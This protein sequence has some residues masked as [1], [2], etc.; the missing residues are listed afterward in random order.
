MEAL[1][2]PAFFWSRSFVL[3]TQKKNR[4]LNT[5]R[6]SLSDC[7]KKIYGYKAQQVQ[8]SYQ[9][10]GYAPL[11]KIFSIFAHA[12]RGSSYLSTITGLFYLPSS[13][14]ISSRIQLPSLWSSPALK[15]R[16]THCGLEQ[17]RI[18]TKVMGHS[19]VRSRIRSHRSLVRL[20]RTARFARALRCAHSLAH[21]A[22]SLAR[23]K[24]NY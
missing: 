11:F 8:K 7:A 23:G 20:L 17:T 5:E 3:F 1:L 2:L 22:H 13:W 14:P 4:I 16:P 12:L 21:F 24:V 19:L 9:C 15:M 18:E 6:L 10:A